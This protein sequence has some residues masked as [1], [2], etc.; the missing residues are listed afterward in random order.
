MIKR[1]VARAAL[2]LPLLMLASAPA[3]ALL[4]PFN[5]S[6]S[7]QSDILAVLDPVGPLVQVESHATGSGVLG[8]VAY[9]SADQVNLGT[10]Q[11]EG[12]NVFTAADG[13]QLF[14]H[15]TV[16]LLPTSDASLLSLIGLVDIVG[17]N[18]RFDGA[19]GTLS[20]SGNGQF[21]SPTQALMN[22]VFEGRVEVVDEPAGL[23]LVLAALL[24]GAAT[25]RRRAGLRC[26]ATCPSSERP[27]CEKATSSA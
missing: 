27:A 15:F 19:D 6:F 9:R 4:V 20:F 18:G 11:G 2:C 14:G 26:L 5:A 3:Q 23:A 13:S 8:L 16:Q 22:F 1:L 21:V 7:G 24:L 12:D 10:G 17:G 25:R